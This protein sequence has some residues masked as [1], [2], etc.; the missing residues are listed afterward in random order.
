MNVVL[1]VFLVLILIL[2]AVFASVYFF[3]FVPS[4]RRRPSGPLVDEYLEKMGFKDLVEEGAVWF[5]SQNPREVHVKSFDGLDLVADFLPCSDARGSIL[6]MHGYHG[7]GLKDFAAV[8]RFFHEQKLNV[9]VPDQRSH[10]RSQGKNITYGIR[11][12][13]DVLSWLNLLNS[14]LVPPAADGKLLPVF[15]D[16]ISMGCATVVMSLGL[17]LP[18]NVRGCIADCGFTSPYEIICHVLKN[19]MHL[20]YFPIIPVARVLCKVAGGFGM[21][22]YSTF[23]ALKNSTVPMLFV[24][25]GADDFVPTEMSIRNYEACTAP[26]KLVIVEAASHAMSYLTDTARCQQELEAFIAE[27]C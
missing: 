9:L 27:N 25:G 15:M 19:M 14:E 5:K 24:H 22:E 6:L 3:Q 17:D 4:I 7:F 11:E 21:K 8:V 13:K 20:P 1:I 10:G 16:G 26:K 2:A 23:E 18:S 12:R